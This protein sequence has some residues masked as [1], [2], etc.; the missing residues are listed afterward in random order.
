[1]P[2]RHAPAAAPVASPRST[3]RSLPKPHVR[4]FVADAQRLGRELSALNRGDDPVR[5]ARSVALQALV[6]FWEEH[7]AGETAPARIIPC[8]ARVEHPGDEAARLAAT[9]G[10]IAARLPHS[11]SGYLLS[12]LYASLLPESL[13]AEQGVFFTPPPLVTRLL[14]LV[15]AAGVDWSTAKI[16]D[17][18]AGGGAF[19]APVAARIERSLLRRGAGSADILDHVTHHLFG[20]ELDPFSTWMAHV[21]L[22]TVLWDHCEATGR[23]IP[24]PTLAG[25]ALQVPDDWKGRFDLVIGNPP[26]GRVTLRDDVRERFSRTLYGHANLYGLFTD[27]AVRLTKPGGIIGYVTPTSFLGGL[28]YK[29]LRSFLAA[30]APPVALDFVADRDNVFEGVLQETL[31]VV[32]APGRTDAGLQVSAIRATALERD[33]DVVPIGCYPAPARSEEPWVLPRTPDTARLVEV[34]RAT[35]SRL[36]D[37][38]FKVSTGP[39]VWNRHKSQ[40]AEGPG[41]GSFPLVWAESVPSKGVFRFQANKRNHTPF[42]RLL[43]NQE[44]LVQRRPCVL[45]QRTTAKEQRRRLIAAVLPQAFLD[46]HGGAVVENHLNMVRS[47]DGE[48]RVSLEA[49]AALL[50]SRIVDQIFRCVNGSVAVSAFELESLPVP[51]PEAM[52]GLEA[53]L[54][55]GGT[56]AEIETYIVDAYGAGA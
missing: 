5:H 45:V 12:S 43:T 42:F 4:D 54:R 26:Y 40:L 19:L 49:I 1:M 3:S 24:G 47:V 9:F 17:P 38:G 25:D 32:Y 28:Y 46:E 33:G 56:E 23:R 36:S 6:S 20:L 37:Y 10:R 35:P 39:L 48:S 15:E 44:H 11:L 50:N 14:D 8:P 7:R 51:G 27:L 52:R 29:R 16:L 41:N 21:L 30:A 34:V 18:A 31:L 53:L 13:R 55:S 22:E 2:S